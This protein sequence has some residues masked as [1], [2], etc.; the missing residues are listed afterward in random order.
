[1]CDLDRWMM[2]KQMAGDPNPH[3]LHI[4]GANVP[5]FLF[6]H[7]RPE[8]GA[9]VTPGGLA[10]GIAFSRS[11][12]SGYDKCSLAKTGSW[13]AAQPSAPALS[14]ASS[15]ITIGSSHGHNEWPRDVDA[16]LPA[17]STT[18]IATAKTT[19][20]IDL[21]PTPGPIVFGA[22]QIGRRSISD[23]IESLTQATFTI[24]FTTVYHSTIK[25]AKGQGRATVIPVTVVTTAILVPIPTN[26]VYPPGVTISDRQA[27][28]VITVASIIGALVLTVGVVACFFFRKHRRSKVDPFFINDPEPA[29]ETTSAVSPCAVVTA[30]ADPYPPTIV[31][32]TTA[33][34]PP[35]SAED[36]YSTTAV[37]N[38]ISG[39]TVA[40][41]GTESM[42]SQNNRGSL[43]SS[44]STATTVLC[45]MVGT[46]VAGHGT[47]S[48]EQQSAR[49]WVISDSS[50][51]SD[52]T[53]ERQLQFRSRTPSSAYE[54]PTPDGPVANFDPFSDPENPFEPPST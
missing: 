50:A 18:E 9:F 29:G 46:T 37:R 35:D 52:A 39:T 33:V 26:Q 25:D 19:R 30:Y 4:P 48:I 54:I 44:L 23:F 42:A 6:A 11:L 13:P 27:N 16:P 15:G 17:P 3:K 31:P 24:T 36:G 51:S 14:T 12:L 40:G 7:N 34:S 32:N 21:V 38:N 5:K 1:M 49:S 45:S 28:T 8:A 41:I 10:A 43:L 22:P 53:H 2:E 20:G 47:E